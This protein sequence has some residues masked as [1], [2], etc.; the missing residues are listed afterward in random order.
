MDSSPFFLRRWLL[1]CVALG[2]LG[3]ALRAVPK[4]SAV[5]EPQILFEKGTAGYVIY[6]IPTLVS[7]A[8]RKEI[9]AIVE[10]RIGSAEDAATTH[11]LVRRSA[12]DGT[13]WSPQRLIHASGDATVGNPCPVLD[14]DTGTLWLFFCVGNRDVWVMSSQDNGVTWRA[15]KDLT[16][17]LRLPK[18]TGF[19]ATGPCQGIQL[20]HGAK[21]GRLIVPAYASEVAAESYTAGSKSFA[22]YSDDHG[23][24]WQVG[25]ST[26]ES[27]TGGPDGNE[28]MATELNDGRLYLTIRNNKTSDGR[29][30]AWSEDAG[31]HWSTVAVDRTLP[32]AVCQV[33]V[34]GYSL[35]TGRSLQL[36]VSPSAAAKGRKD[37]SARRDLAVWSSAD[38]CRTWQKAGLL[39]AGPAA[40]SDQ[41]VLRDGRVGV[42]F[43]FGDKRYDEK[44][45]FL[46]YRISP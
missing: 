38:D 29:G 8:D 26:Q 13:T 11:I 10:G 37:K 33:S 46:R 43:E 23:K 42:I 30:Y 35:S 24:T 18:H 19:Y 1:C 32:E 4:L 27:T 3:S 40:Y 7:T 21:K 14:A 20:K 41:V 45:G 36:Y 5:D 39:K 34:I 25:G 15:P 9:L 31:S 12:D 16:P 44:I 28:C 2:S 17:Q 22:I 6:K